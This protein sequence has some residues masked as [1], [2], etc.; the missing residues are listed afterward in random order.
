L[1]YLKTC[2]QPQ[3]LPL[4]R[5]LNT[6]ARGLG[7]AVVDHIQQESCRHGLSFVKVVEKYEQ[8][9]FSPQHKHAFEEFWRSVHA[10]KESLLH[11]VAGESPSQALI[12]WVQDSGY[13]V[14]LQRLAG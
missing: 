2:L 11:P 13:R 12:R 8:L 6:P 4:R 7:V 5:I 10:L 3:E 9:D 14:H 1:A